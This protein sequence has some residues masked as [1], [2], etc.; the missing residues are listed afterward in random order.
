MRFEF[1]VF[2][3]ARIG[4]QH[5]T[6]VMSSV[7]EACNL[8]DAGFCLW[9]GAGVTV[10]LAQGA[11]AVPQWPQLTRELERLGEIG[12][13]DDWTYPRRLDACSK[14]L[15]E[16][17][18]RGELRRR[19]YTNF[20]LTLL[21]R[22]KQLLAEDDFIPHEVRQVASL[23]QAANP[24]VNFNIEPLSSVLLARP[25]GPMRVV[26]YSQP[27]QN[28]LT[29]DEA[30]E[31]Y[32]RLIYHPHG[33]ITGSYVMTESQYGSMGATLAFRLATHAAFGGILAIV[34][35]SLED[36]YLREQIT[37]FRGDL[38]DIF[39]FNSRFEKAPAEWAKANNVHM[40]RTEWAA[41]WEWWFT[42]RAREVSE[43]HLCAAWY[44]VL[45][46]AW[47]EV[48]G[49]AAINTYLSLAQAGMVEDSIQEKSK[50]LGEPGRRAEGY[51]DLTGVLDEV[52]HRI[53]KKG[54]PLPQV[55]VTF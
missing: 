20:G 48:R 5:G 14:E 9:I 6:V 42:D 23:G 35:M 34:G 51:D 22:A 12:A 54:F 37:A 28:V 19:Y 32:R 40:L 15:G 3:L 44:R 16:G 47:D 11:A 8:M 25:C 43:E 55:A 38:K 4:G 50:V 41:F 18:F 21:R 46:E 30:S 27:Y 53:Q 7:F 10:H 31:R 49:G 26:S 52:A 45:T 33:L 36:E 39:W 13:P 29:H 17:A 2:S 24:I 1:S